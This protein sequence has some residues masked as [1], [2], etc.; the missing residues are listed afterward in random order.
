MT[1]VV[2][3]PPAQRTHR[4]ELHPERP[5]DR[6][7][8][9]LDPLRGLA[10][11]AVI[12]FHAYQNQTLGE[13]TTSEL[14]RRLLAVLVTLSDGAVALFFVLS[15]FVLYL[16]AV[17]AGLAGGR[18]SSA[19]DMLMRRAARLLPLYYTVILL[20]W[21]IS[22]TS[23]PG[24]WRDLLLHTTMTHVYSQKYIFWTDGPAW[25][26][27]V[28]FHFYLLMALT[29]PVIGRCCAGTTAGA[30]RSALVLLLPLAMCAAGIAW[31]FWAVHHRA[32]DEWPIWF[33]PLAKMPIFAF[34]MLLAV[35]VAHG[36]EL[37]HAWTRWS[38]VVAGFGLVA[39][40]VV[41]RPTYQDSATSELWHLVFATV[42]VLWIA[43][44]VMNPY[45]PSR[46]LSWRPLAFLGVISYGIYL[47]HE[48]TMRVL[49]SH[50]LLPHRDGG[51][52]D[53]LLTTAMV[54]GVTILVA[55]LSFRYIELNGL[56]V[57]AAFEPG[58]RSR[59][60]YPHLVDEVDLPP[61]RRRAG[62][63]HR[64]GADAADRRRPWPRRCDRARVRDV[65]RPTE[66]NRPPC[67]R[68]APTSFQLA[69]SGVGVIPSRR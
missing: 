39:L 27:A 13:V 37:R 32:V 44:I 38:L 53:F 35:V 36:A 15:G 28:E 21:S 55:R 4:R 69:C 8:F 11:V 33:G 41:R 3:A 60:Y 54:L 65:T 42:A 45:A 1:A 6:R 20:V 51:Q 26:L 22:N 10:A 67:G 5:R 61:R 31:L 34:G 25:S 18:P 29:V 63:R 43:A 16:P 68:L 48:P 24:Q 23:L 66:S 12:F 62:N 58:G 17:R 50:G 56:R 47:L 64:A 57:L 19:I 40:A 7:R 2:A 52:W 49:R 9:P 14:D 46:W 59:E 30:R